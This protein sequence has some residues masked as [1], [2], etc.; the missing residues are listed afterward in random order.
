MKILTIITLAILALPLAN[1]NEPKSF[2]EISYLCHTNQLDW[3]SEECQDNN[4]VDYL[5]NYN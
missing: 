1:T 5:L 4:R 3:N 2:S